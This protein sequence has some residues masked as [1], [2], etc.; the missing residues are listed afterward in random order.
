VWTDG[1]LACSAGDT[2]RIVDAI[3]TGRVTTKATAAEMF[4]SAGREYG[5]GIDSR[6][7]WVGHA[8]SYGGFESE[9]WH[10][11]ARR[12]TIVALAN[13]EDV[14]AASEVWQAIAGTWR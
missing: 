14:A 4:P 7:R 12:L 6:D 13:R 9:G 5:L 2:A 8:G 1:G 10:D 3:L 11:R